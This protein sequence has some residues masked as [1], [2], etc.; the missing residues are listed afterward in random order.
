MWNYAQ[1]VLYG[2]VF[3][4]PFDVGKRAV[5]RGHDVIKTRIDL[6]ILGGELSQFRTI[7]RVVT[8]R[9]KVRKIPDYNYVIWVD[10][11]E[12]LESTPP[13]FWVLMG[14]VCV[15]EDEDFSVQASLGNG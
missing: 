2:P 7:P 8:K 11:R 10:I 3:M 13:G 14:D 1:R 12:E 4:I 5:R 9:F 6:F 15:W